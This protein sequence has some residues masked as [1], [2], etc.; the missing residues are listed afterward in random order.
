MYRYGAELPLLGE[1]HYIADVAAAGARRPCRHR[2]NEH[3]AIYMVGANIHAVAAK[4]AAASKQPLVMLEI[5]NGSVPPNSIRGPRQSPLQVYQRDQ[6]LG[7]GGQTFAYAATRSIGGLRASLR[8]QSTHVQRRSRLAEA[9]MVGV[10]L[11]WA[12]SQIA[13]KV[14]SWLKPTF[15]ALSRERQ[16]CPKPSRSECPS[17]DMNERRKLGSPR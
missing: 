7:G 1:D 6:S 2:P 8:R 10:C 4:L 13:A 16:V 14:R 5:P 17:C 15:A 3:T 11:A 12:G 9:A